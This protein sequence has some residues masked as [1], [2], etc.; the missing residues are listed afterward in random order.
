M[1]VTSP[2]HFLLMDHLFPGA[3]RLSSFEEVK[4]G[5]AISTAIAV[6]ISTAANA[7]MVLLQSVMHGRTSQRFSFAHITLNHGRLC[8]CLERDVIQKC[9]DS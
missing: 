8:E 7:G 9:S 2:L 3:N 4:A 5:D 1:Q 6:M